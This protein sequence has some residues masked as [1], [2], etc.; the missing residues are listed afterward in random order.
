MA[1]APAV[2]QHAKPR[3]V[4]EPKGE[5]DVRVL[6]VLF[7]MAEERWRTPDFEEVDFEDFPLQGPGWADRSVFE[8]ASLCRVL[9]YMASYD[10]L[11]LPAL[12]SAEA[13]MIE[14]ARRLLH[15]RLRRRS[16]GSGS[17]LTEASSTL[18]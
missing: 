14:V 7:D 9:D 12:A 11:N 2:S 8:H 18:H 4:V 6:P 3:V 15:T 1:E 13:L 10:Q 5:R 17:L 16:W